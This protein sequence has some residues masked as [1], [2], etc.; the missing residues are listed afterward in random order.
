MQKA[1]DAWLWGYKGLAERA[2][3]LGKY[4][5]PIRPKLHQIDEAFQTAKKTGWNTG[6]DWCFEDERAMKYFKNV[7]T[8]TH[9]ATTSKRGLER[10]LVGFCCV[11]VGE[12]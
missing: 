3:S 8:K 10:W 12:E 6:N 2:F 1:R 9:V 7:A 11:F 4:R 5:L